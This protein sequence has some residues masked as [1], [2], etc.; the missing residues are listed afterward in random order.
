VIHPT[1]R[2]HFKWKNSVVFKMYKTIMFQI[3]NSEAVSMRADPKQRIIW[4]QSFYIIMNNR[5]VIVGLMD[6]MF[7]CFCNGVETNDAATPRCKP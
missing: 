7:D 4:K 3:V 6:I 5:I 2:I 1:R